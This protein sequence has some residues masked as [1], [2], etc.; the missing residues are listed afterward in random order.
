ML[1]LSKMTDYAV[2]ILTQLGREGSPRSAPQLAEK[3]GLPE[4]TVCKV[5][6]SLARGKLVESARGVSGGYRLARDVNALSV[7]DVI[8]AID[9]PI[10]IASCVE[11]M[12]DPC[13]AEGRCPSRGKWDGANRAIR[14]ALQDIKVGDMAA[15]SCGALSSGPRLFNISMPQQAEAE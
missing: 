12:E 6:K 9:G 4:P 3:T 15:R 5:L 8:E 1:R 13:V 2:V 7:C 14:A 11:G 10:A